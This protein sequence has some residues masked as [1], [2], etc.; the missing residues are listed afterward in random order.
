MPE[1]GRRD[2]HPYQTGSAA[3]WLET[4]CTGFHRDS[5]FNESHQVTPHA[6]VEFWHLGHHIGHQKGSAVI[7]FV[8]SAI[9]TW[10]NVSPV[11]AASRVI[12]RSDFVRFSGEGFAG[13]EIIFSVSIPNPRAIQLPRNPVGGVSFAVVGEYILRLHR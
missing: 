12:A 11:V 3:L 4:L 13:T 8:A 6:S 10:C 7:R 9:S 5:R 2:L 1:S